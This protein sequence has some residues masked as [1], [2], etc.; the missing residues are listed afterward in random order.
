MI[1][2]PFLGRARQRESESG[3]SGSSAASGSAG[4]SFSARQHYSTVG[5]QSRSTPPDRGGGV[6]MRRKYLIEDEE[7]AGKFAKYSR[8][9]GSGGHFRTISKIRGNTFMP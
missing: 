3:T 4:A 5:M 8:N 7:L 2:S 9:F 1:T 6:A